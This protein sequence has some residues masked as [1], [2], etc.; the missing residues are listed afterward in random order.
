MLKISPNDHGIV[1]QFSTR[2]EAELAFKKGSSH[3]G[4][5]MK[6][7]WLEEGSGN[8]TATGTGE[9]AESSPNGTGGIH[10]MFLFSHNSHSWRRGKRRD[11]INSSGTNP[12]GGLERKCC[13]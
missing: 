5:I 2:R 8:V 13:G 10:S 6:I 9:G 11:C 3:A 12:G 7:D 1:V 4:Q